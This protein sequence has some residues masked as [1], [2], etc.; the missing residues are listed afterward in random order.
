MY[1]KGVYESS[2]N[3][4]K[5]NSLYRRP[6]IVY[7]AYYFLESGTIHKEKVSKL[8]YYLWK[9]FRKGW[10]ERNFFCSEC[11]NTFKGIIKNERDKV[12]CPNC[13]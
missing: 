3:V 5:R 13:S 1:Y 12:D 10:K 7:M 2:N 6:P 9:W 8:T 4:R 11:E